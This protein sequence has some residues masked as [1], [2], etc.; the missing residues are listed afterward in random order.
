[1]IRRRLLFKAALNVARVL[2][3]VATVVSFFILWSFNPS[4]GRFLFVLLPLLALASF[5]SARAALVPWS[6]YIVGFLVFV[7]LRMISAEVLFAARYNYVIDITRFLFAGHID[8]VVLQNALYRQDAPDL[9]D[10]VLIGVHV[11]FFI[12]PHITAAWLWATQRDVFRRYVVALV[13]T[14][15]F[16]LIVAFL[17]PTAPPW[18]AAHEGLIPPV[19]RI[20]REF[21]TG[22]SVHYENGLRVVGENDVAAM[23]SLH[24]ALTVLVA[25]G[26]S[27][28]GKVGKCVGWAYAAAMMFTLVYL[29]EHYTV[30]IIAGAGSALLFWHMTRGLEGSTAARAEA[31]VPSAIPEPAGQIAK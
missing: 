19:H 12:V 15:W 25:L 24:T 21:L 6:I 8:V 11:S 4:A 13:A 7:D 31:S 10:R 18:L 2:L 9:L 14:C 26:L 23:P 5:A 3:V 27:R 20:M 30:D 28:Y 1:M 17:V 29:G 22:A 16:G